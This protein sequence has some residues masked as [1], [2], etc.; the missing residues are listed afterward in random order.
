MLFRSNSSISYNSNRRIYLAS[1]RT[2]SS[3]VSCG[4]EY[5]TQYVEYIKDNINNHLTLRNILE[6]ANFEF[7]DNIEDADMNFS[8]PT[9][10]MFMNLLG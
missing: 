6:Q 3:E 7:V 4:S 10:D 8:K 2:G 5:T 9:K 1:L